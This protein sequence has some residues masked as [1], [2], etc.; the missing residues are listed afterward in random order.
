[1][2]EFSV[3]YDQLP[4]GVAPQLDHMELCSQYEKQVWVKITLGEVEK[5]SD[6]SICGKDMVKATSE[7]INSC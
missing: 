1:M 3:K 6:S 5:G 7:Q 4:R 2:S